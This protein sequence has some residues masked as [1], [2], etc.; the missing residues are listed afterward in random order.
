[1]KALTEQQEQLLRFLKSCDRC[2]TFDEMQ[3]ALGLKS[4]SGVHRLIGA[5]EAKGFI[6]RMPGMARAIEVVPDPHLPTNLNAFS[7]ADLAREARRRGLALC[8]YHRD[9]TD[10]FA[11][12]SFSEIRA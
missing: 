2:P 7:V 3:A 8:E 11:P 1:M 4:K 5:L 10:P 6:R 12:R 9:C